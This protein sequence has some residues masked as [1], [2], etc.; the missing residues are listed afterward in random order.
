MEFV[1]I[2]KFKTK[3][4]YTDEQ[5]LLAEKEIRKALAEQ[6]GFLYRELGKF[7]NGY[8]IVSIHW[9]SKEA[10]SQWTEN[11]KK[12]DS[13]KNQHQMIDFTTMRMEFYEKIKLED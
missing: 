8:W 11:S 10:G 6:E 1:G 13:V 7:S 5:M 3:P 12:Y 2:A 4:E 9:S